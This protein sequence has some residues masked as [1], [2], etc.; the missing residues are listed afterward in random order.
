MNRKT[1]PFSKLLLAGRHT[2]S[3]SLPLRSPIR[4][5]TRVG[6][7]GDG[8][9]DGEELVSVLPLR[10]EILELLPALWSGLPL[11]MP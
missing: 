3:W 1:L 10:E 6:I 5:L 11:R 2:S 9:E 8:D 7:Q 4:S